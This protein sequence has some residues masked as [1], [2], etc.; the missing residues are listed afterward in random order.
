M[1]DQSLAE[2]IAKTYSVYFGL[3]GTSRDPA[4]L[5]YALL[6]ER[7]GPIANKMP[8]IAVAT[9]P[10]SSLWAATGLLG[11]RWLVAIPLGVVSF[12]RQ[13]CAI[14]FLARESYKESPSLESAVNQMSR[15]LGEQLEF[16]LVDLSGADYL[17]QKS[18]PIIEHLTQIAYEFFILHE[19]CHAMYRHEEPV[20]HDTTWYQ[21]AHSR[22]ANEFWADRW[23]FNTLLA[24]FSNDMNLVTVAIALLFDA[25]DALDRFDFSPMA[26]VTHPSPAARKWHIMRLLETPESL[27]FLDPEKLQE[28]KNFSLLY[29]RLASFI[30]DRGKPAT[31]LNRELNQGAEAGP[32]AFIKAMLP[33]LARG[34]PDR[35]VHNLPL[36]RESTATWAEEGT[37]DD[38]AFAIKVNDCIDELGHEL[39]TIPRLR[40]LAAALLRMASLNASSQVGGNQ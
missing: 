20:A 3:A 1:R 36:V 22:H 10:R 34:D 18:K 30:V 19:A 13:F 4:N 40:G 26:R 38:S 2:E 27:D 9:V 37:G 14:V 6:L 12:Y 15:L 24:S 33:I 7:L 16:G 25:L 35:I 11:E 28:A 39:D 5:S 31:P 32:Q 17:P 21:E 23:A 8:P 29:E